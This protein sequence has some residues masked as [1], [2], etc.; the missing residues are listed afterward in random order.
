[1]PALYRSILAPVRVEA[2]DQQR[3]VPQLVQKL[4]AHTAAERLGELLSMLRRLAAQVLGY[5]SPE[6]VDPE[7]TFQ[8]IG[9]DSLSGVEF[10]NEV[11]KETD[12]Q[13]AAT[14]VYD[15]P[16]PAGLAMHVRDRL[17]PEDAIDLDDMITDLRDSIDD[18]SDDEIDAMGVD[19]LIRL[20]HADEDAA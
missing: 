14:V 2:N 16:T 1:M 8:E 7:A 4:G 12:L 19:D 18:Q 10:R 17:F 5:P 6:D 13:L 3:A 11:R 15:Y 9:F 20:A